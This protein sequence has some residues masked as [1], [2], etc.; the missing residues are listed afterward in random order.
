ME[1]I[2][3]ILYGND[4][5]RDGRESVKRA[6]AGPGEDVFGR[7]VFVHDGVEYVLE[8]RL[9]G[10]GMKVEAELSSQGMVLANGHSAV[11]EAVSEVI[12]M[13]F[14]AFETSVFTKQNELAAFSSLTGGVRKARLLKIMRIELIDRA[15]DSVRA[16]GR[17]LKQ[18]RDGILAVLEHS[19]PIEE[20]QKATR[21]LKEELDS[22]AKKI[23]KYRHDEEHIKKKLKKTQDGCQ[24]ILKVVERQN[25]MAK[26]HET[27][28]NDL[29]VLEGEIAQLE[30]MK[31]TLENK[32]V[33]LEKL[34]DV[35]NQYNAAF[36]DLEAMR[37][38]HKRHLSFLEFF[39]THQEISKKIRV[40]K[41][42]IEQLAI[43]DFDINDQK[44]NEEC[45]TE[46]SQRRLALTKEASSLREK[47][48][49][50]LKTVQETQTHIKDIEN[51][52]E[53]TPC[54]TCLRPLGEHH[55]F[56]TTSLRKEIKGAQQK[57]KDIE[58][59]LEHVDDEWKR[60]EKKN[61]ELMK[62]KKNLFEKEKKYLKTVERRDF[63]KDVLEK[64]ALE[65]ANTEKRM[66]ELPRDFDENAF[67]NLKNMTEE[68]KSARKE[69]NTLTEDVLRLEKIL[70]K[71][72]EKIR[73]VASKKEETSK[74]SKKLAD[75]DEHLKKLDVAQ[76]EKNEL[77]AGQ[78]TLAGMIR[79]L[80]IKID[81]E[82]RE[83]L[84]IGKECEKYVEKRKLLEIINDDI[85]V[86]NETET[87]LV[88]FKNFIV[89]KLGPRMA[90]RVSLLLSDMTG[91]VYSE[92]QITQDYGLEIFSDGEYRALKRF[93]GGEQDLANLALRLSISHMVS[94]THGSGALGIVILDEVF[95]SL[96][97]HYLR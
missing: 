44:R 97:Q 81:Y 70:K 16:D 50:L 26:R 2:A 57:L 14:P 85:H 67:T 9:R 34:L 42:E 17:I 33:A 86:T 82:N 27:L 49:W 13:D 96:D 66:D 58:N 55:G 7:L 11:L 74:L 46:I 61:A 62:E 84:R 89:E 35:D 60:L 30:E 22:A 31:E 63:L 25:E 75:R 79:E 28:T 37:E 87:I 94:E 1:G 78:R 36:V 91:G 10:K 64:L 29:R 72:E 32:K 68:L 38:H 6:E 95:S 3:W 21:T 80:T 90:D 24:H 69:K 47:K 43:P 92:V 12:G 73:I 8:R 83:L 56:L 20:L 76:K 48:E 4:V 41:D 53:K 54:P 51:L 77:E 65:L 5:A 45:I 15:V 88:G 71:R 18:K 59:G 40:T 23:E 19:K 39:R 93:S 52:G